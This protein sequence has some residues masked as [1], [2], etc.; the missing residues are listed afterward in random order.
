M[1]SAAVITFDIQSAAVPLPALQANLVANYP[2]KFVKVI[3]RRFFG[4]AVNDT[5]EGGDLIFIL[6]ILMGAWRMLENM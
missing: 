3:A 6:L 4:V 1:G 5:R 2:E